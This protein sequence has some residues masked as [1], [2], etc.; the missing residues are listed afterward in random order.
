MPYYRKT[1]LCICEGQ[2]EEMYLAH[3][4]SLLKKFPNRVVK[5]NT[6]I[7]KPYRLNK[8]YE[9]YD[10][11]ALF[12]YDLNEV[13]FRKNIECCDQLNNAN[14]PTKRKKGKYT[15]HAF[16]NVNFDLWLILHK[17]DFNRSV[18]SNSAY[19]ADVKRIYGL[20][21]SEN[22]KSKSAI[23]KILQ[24][25]TLEDVKSAI[26]RA[27]KIRSEKMEADKMII[28][29]TVCYPNPDFSIH[30]FLKVVLKDCGEL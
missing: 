25:I 11:A 30:E 6:M 16:S 17:E 15:Y 4:A 24:Q 2:Q 18:S 14:K 10:N 23:E 26:S 13:E 29:S 9:E 5:F 28:G 19:Q 22:I 3:V 7:D 21:S 12:D 8:T 27:D 1:Y 20:G